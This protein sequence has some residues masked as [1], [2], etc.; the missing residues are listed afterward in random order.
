MKNKI[1]GLTALAVSSLGLIANVNAVKIVG[2]G[3]GSEGTIGYEGS[4]VTVE[5]IGS[6]N[7][8]YK[9]T[10]IG[11][12]DEDLTIIAGETVIIDLFGYTWTNYDIH[13]SAIVVE[14]G[15]KL[16]IMDSKTN[17]KITYKDE[18]V[19][20]SNYY[21]DLIQNKGTLIFQSG[22]IEVNKGSSTINSNPKG[23]GIENLENA[24][25]IIEGGT[26]KTIGNGSWGIVNKGVATIKGGTLTQ[27]GDHSVILNAKDMTI[28]D[29]LFNQTGSNHNS[30]IT[31]DDNTNPKLEIKGG[32]FSVESKIFHAKA[33]GD[34]KD[35]II[36]GGKFSTDP[37]RQT[38]IKKYMDEEKYEITAE[39]EVVTDA[40][41]EEYNAVL[42]EAENKVKETGKYTEVSLKN[43][44][45][46][47]EEAK[48]IA[49]DLK[50]NEQEKIDNAVKTLKKAISGLKLIPTV[51]DKNDETP[52]NNPGTYDL[53]IC[54]ILL[55]LAS[56]TSLGFITFRALKK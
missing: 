12:C 33:S 22:T 10:L 16:T 47:I 37:E 21:P 5:E 56:L 6:N 54:Y 48:K 27:G 49:K 4:N 13:S 34:N 20:T 35:I 9:L 25:L 32:E 30:L 26:I 41:Y 55:A 14:S 39:G 45:N 42:E 1:I 46:A 31:N 44:Q 17:G 2:T 52:N 38:E 50:S 53:F 15:A 8:E 3:S 19:A 11:P 29:G 24:N 7:H 40:D 23:T 51:S 28:E 36:T 18:T 43:L